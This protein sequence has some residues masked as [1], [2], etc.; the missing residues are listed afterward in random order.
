MIDIEIIP[1]QYQ[2]QDSTLDQLI[3]LHRVANRLGMYDAA[4]VL[5]LLIEKS[6]R[7]EPSNVPQWMRET[8]AFLFD[9]GKIS[10][11]KV[12]RNA[13]GMLLKDSLLI[14][15]HLEKHYKLGVYAPTQY[16][17][18][19]DKPLS[20]MNEEQT[21]LFHRFVTLIEAEY[22]ELLKA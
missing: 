6:Q 14:V 5:R 18:L 3:D 1:P 4:E 9:D 13:T 12:I 11:I 21:N 20:P 10:A 17:F 8:I 16:S 2:R 19:A 15:S 7:A 22:S